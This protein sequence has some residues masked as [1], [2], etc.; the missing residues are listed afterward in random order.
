MRI[1]GRSADR[2]SRARVARATVP[3]FEAKTDRPWL[4]ILPAAV[5]KK[6]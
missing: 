5:P 4:T 2:K 6:P 1:I 3:G